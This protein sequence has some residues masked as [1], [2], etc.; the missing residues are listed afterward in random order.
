[1]DTSTPLSFPA[2]IRL[3]A[4]GRRDPYFGLSRSSWYRLHARG[5]ISFRR[6]S[7]TGSQRGG[8]TLIP[9][10]DARRALL[11]DAP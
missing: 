8:C 5:L 4:H 3:P 7:P 9:F 6:T 10:A 11:G 2:A 1:M